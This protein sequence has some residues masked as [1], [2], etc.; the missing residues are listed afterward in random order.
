[1][2]PIPTKPFW[3]NF[4]KKICKRKSRECEIIGKI[5][6][7]KESENKKGVFEHRVK[8]INMGVNDREEIIKYIF[9]EERKNLRKEKGF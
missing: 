1:M 3:N 7:V 5:L 4:K 8:Y 2:P 9:E 6:S